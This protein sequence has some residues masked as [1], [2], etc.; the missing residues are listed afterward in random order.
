MSLSAVLSLAISSNNGGF[1]MNKG[2]F[3]VNK[4]KFS[5]IQGIRIQGTQDLCGKPVN[6]VQGKRGS[7]GLSYSQK[8]QKFKETKQQENEK[9]YFSFSQRDSGTIKRQTHKGKTTFYLL[10]MLK[11]PILKSDKV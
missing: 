10:N 3:G 6:T 7:R 9:S 2:V 11:N 4:P 5:Q 8:A 1:H